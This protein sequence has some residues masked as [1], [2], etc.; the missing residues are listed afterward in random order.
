[1]AVVTPC[2]SG[3]KFSG[4]IRRR[5]ERGD[6]RTLGPCRSGLLKFR[7]KGFRVSQFQNIDSVL[8]AKAI[9]E[10]PGKGTSP[11]PFSFIPSRGLNLEFPSGYAM[12]KGK[13]KGEESPPRLGPLTGGKA[14]TDL[15]ALAGPE[16]PVSQLEGKWTVVIHTFGQKHLGCVRPPAAVIHAPGGKGGSSSR[17]RPSVAGESAW[18][19][20]RRVPGLAFKAR[21][22]EVS[23]V[24]EAARAGWREDGVGKVPLD[25]DAYLH[26]G[27]GSPFEFQDPEELPDD[28]EFYVR[29]S[30]QH[31]GSCGFMQKRQLRDENNKKLFVKAWKE[32][33][34]Q[35]PAASTNARFRASR[36]HRPGRPELHIGIS[37]QQ[38]RHRAEMMSGWSQSILETFADVGEVVIRRHHLRAGPHD[39]R[40]P[41]GCRL[42]NCPVFRR[43]DQ[44][45][46]GELGV[47]LRDQ[48]RAVARSL[49]AQ[50]SDVRRIDREDRWAG[51]APVQ[52]SALLVRVPAPD[53]EVAP[54]S[55]V[56]LGR[57]D[58][59]ARTAEESRAASYG[60]RDSQTPAFDDPKQG[61]L[62]P[63]KIGPGWRVFQI[64]PDLS[65]S[66][67]FPPKD[68]VPIRGDS[69]RG[70]PAG[71]FLGEVLEVSHTTRFVAVRIEHPVTRNKVWVNVW[72]NRNASGELRGTMFCSVR[73]PGDPTPL[74]PEAFETGEK[75]TEVDLSESE[76]DAPGVQAEKRKGAQGSRQLP[77]KS[78]KSQA[79]ESA[80]A[81][82]KAGGKSP[83]PGPQR[84][85]RSPSAPPS[86]LRRAGPAEPTGGTP[87]APSADAQGSLGSG[88]PEDSTPIG[89]AVAVVH[90]PPGPL[91]PD[92]LMASLA[93]EQW[94]Q[95]TWF[96]GPPY[97][98]KSKRAPP[99]VA[100]RIGGQKVTCP[101]VGCGM[102]RAVFAIGSRYVFKYEYAWVAKYSNKA[103]V[104]S[105]GSTPSGYRAWCLQWSTSW[106][107]RRPPTPWST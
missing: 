45:R 75:M 66:W 77:P 58:S 61:K 96:D 72:T 14:A 84:R 89:Q 19:Q 100:L 6:L 67:A 38:G 69:L 92:E 103:E 81:V 53:T 78:Q 17:G 28:F 91:G 37:C 95:I 24:S 71:G 102:S 60:G 15:P 87:R 10:G 76:E 18:D 55:E 25:F 40:G 22:D 79:D 68:L 70:V 2:I 11:Q 27:R 51:C 106:F 63:R 29:V 20:L 36:Q 47:K 107:Q 12:G 31:D 52:E 4:P 97:P 43:L 73:A 46:A 5:V 80:G 32:L 3:P 50:A 39:D 93:P 23:A 48:A 49:A 82:A 104:G 26:V 8:A 86:K 65:R 42:D 34:S 94:S 85:L 21:P 98:F 41:C 56:V 7:A 44:M 54:V 74:G 88:R 57:R 64:K 13:A 35:F 33:V 62:R 59:R 9:T 16:S 30:K 83:G 1:M 90:A 105:P 99:E 101:L